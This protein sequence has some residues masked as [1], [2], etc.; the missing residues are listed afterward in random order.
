MVP[1]ARRASFH[2]WGFSSK[3]IFDWGFTRPGKLLPKTMENHHAFLMGKFT[4]S[5]GPWLQSLRNKLPEGRFF[6]S[7]LFAFF[8]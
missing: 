6:D 4:I 7:D 1:M 5:T 8:C 3:A 2:P